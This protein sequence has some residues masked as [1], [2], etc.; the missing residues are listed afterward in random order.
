MKLAIALFILLTASSTALA[1]QAADSVTV[2]GAR[3]RAEVERYLGSVSVSSAVVGKIARWE[4]H[5]VCPVVVGLRP[6]Y[7][8]FITARIRSVAQEIGAPVNP[9]TDCAPNIRIV[10][11][12]AP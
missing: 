2:T 3:L 4:R 9:K 7:L 11:T 12:T 5:A 8:S 6:E 1:Q 10:F